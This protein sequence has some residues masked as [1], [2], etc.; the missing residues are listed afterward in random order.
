MLH[1]ADRQSMI[2]DLRYEVDVEEISL[3]LQRVQY[4]DAI[5][6]EHILGMIDKKN[7]QEWTGRLTKLLFT[8]LN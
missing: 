7:A 5:K 4:N 6:I 2:S 8:M 1:T 3:G